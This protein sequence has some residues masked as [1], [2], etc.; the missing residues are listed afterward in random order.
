MVQGKPRIFDDLK[1]NRIEPRFKNRQKQ[2][3]AIPT[4]YRYRLEL[5]KSYRLSS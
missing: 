3:L 1:W 2:R 5:N 4:E